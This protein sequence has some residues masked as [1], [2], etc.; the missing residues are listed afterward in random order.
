MAEQQT[1]VMETPAAPV[2]PT[3]PRKGKGPATHEQ[4]QKRRKI[5]RR[6]IALVL[7]AAILGGGGWALN[8]Y[9]F[10]DSD[11]GLGEVMTQM[12][13]YGSI[14]SSVDGMGNARAKNS[15][16]VTPDAGYRVLE[17]FV[18]EGDY[19]EEGQ[20]RKSVV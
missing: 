17:L 4:K 16:T 5:I 9:V 14:Q 19:V 10:T 7:A 1:P 6:V 20:D 18:S 12:V 3:G 13:T 15:A 8:K 2:P 11:Q